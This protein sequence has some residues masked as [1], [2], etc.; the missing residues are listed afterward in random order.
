MSLLWTV[1]DGDG[2]ELHPLGEAINII[3]ESL[4]EGGSYTSEEH[5]PPTVDDL[6]PV[7]GVL[8]EVWSYLTEDGAAVFHQHELNGPLG[9]PHL[10]GGG[11]VLLPSGMKGSRGLLLLRQALEVLRSEIELDEAVWLPTGRSAVVTLNNVSIKE[12]S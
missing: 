10:G 11:D 8:D 5:R 2:V 7:D 1:S 6:I 9:G 3:R 4:A 12:A